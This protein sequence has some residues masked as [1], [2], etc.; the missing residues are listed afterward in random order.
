MNTNSCIINPA[1]LIDHLDYKS[2]DNPRYGPVKALQM[3][4]HLNVCVICTR[5]ISQLMGMGSVEVF[6][7]SSDNGEWSQWLKSSISKLY[8]SDRILPIRK[9]SKLEE[10]LIKAKVDFIDVEDVDEK[11]QDKNMVYISENILKSVYRSEIFK[12][13]MSMVTLVQ[14]RDLP[15][16]K[17]IIG[18]L[19]RA[20][21][22]DSAVKTEL[23]LKVVMPYGEK[24]YPLADRLRSATRNFIADGLAIRVEK[25]NIEIVD[26]AI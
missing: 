11:N 14:F 16:R 13:M 20:D 25:I 3:E 22:Y 24:L 18:V 5:R 19:A 1:E 12:K 15:S 4:K 8:C 21:R 7:D 6:T 9:G 2:G 23:F 10:A 26:I 17:P